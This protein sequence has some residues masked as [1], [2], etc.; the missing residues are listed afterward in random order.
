MESFSYLRVV[1]KDWVNLCWILLE[2]VDVFFMLFGG[3]VVFF[4]VFICFGR[5]YV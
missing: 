5:V 1:Y 4:V 2:K 3:K